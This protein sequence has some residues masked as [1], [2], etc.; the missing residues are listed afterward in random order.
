MKE[1]QMLKDNLCTIG[2][3]VEQVQHIRSKECLK[4]DLYFRG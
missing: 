1:I 3:N 4:F 2:T